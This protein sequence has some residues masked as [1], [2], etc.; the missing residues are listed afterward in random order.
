MTNFSDKTVNLTLPNQTE[1]KTLLTAVQLLEKYAAGERRFRQAQLKKVDLKGANLAGIDLRGSDLS[2]ANFKEADLS[3]A[4]LREACLV[5]VDFSKANL[6]R[7]NLQGSRLD[8]TNLKEANLTRASFK[9][10]MLPG[11]FL[12]KAIAIRANFQGSSLIGA[13]LNEADLSYANLANAYLDAAYLIQTNL[14]RAT[15]TETSLIGTFL[16]GAAMNGANFKGGYYTDKTNFD[17]SFDPS[18]AGLRKANKTTLE[19]VMRAFTHLG[20][21]ANRYVG[22]KMTARYWESSRPDCEWLQNFQ[23]DASGQIIF[24]GNPQETLTFA[25]LLACSQWSDNFVKSCSAIVGQFPSLIDP[26]LLA[27]F[28]D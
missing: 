6:S 8:K 21:C 25:R 7:A 27:F 2:Y 17:V 15:L 16:S 13:H 4:D 11:A 10:A 19:E 20:E 12:T 1:A 5:G 18:S 22:T 23:I 24:A 14:Q 3:N 9:E 28:S 26:E